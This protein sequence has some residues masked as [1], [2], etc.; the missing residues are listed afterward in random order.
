MSTFERDLAKMRAYL[1]SAGA[2]LTLED[3]SVWIDP[4]KADPVMLSA[5]R[6]LL[7]YGYANGLIDVGDAA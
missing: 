4:D 2:L 6:G 7:S 3:G 5:Y 1:E